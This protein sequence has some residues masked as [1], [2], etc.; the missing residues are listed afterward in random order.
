M[1]LGPQFTLTV[2][3]WLPV[4]TSSPLKKKS[5]G[6]IEAKV[7]ACVVSGRQSFAKLDGRWYSGACCAAAT[8]RQA[9]SRSARSV[10]KRAMIEASR[11][12]KCA[13]AGDKIQIDYWNSTK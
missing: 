3:D 11:S 10:P 12:K 7:V 5:D 4:L 8:A 1:A 13:S 6:K 9:A 2:V